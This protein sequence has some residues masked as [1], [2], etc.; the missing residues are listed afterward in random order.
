MRPDTST[1]RARFTFAWSLHRRHC[2]F[3]DSASTQSSCCAASDTAK[4]A[5]R[6]CWHRA[7]SMSAST[8]R[9]PLCNPQLETAHIMPLML[10]ADT[11]DFASVIRPGDT[12]AWGQSNA[13]PL[14]LTRKLL[15]QRHD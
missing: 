5:L 10:E 9:K 3:R 15:E 13:E 14:A 12:V 1:S 2:A 8:K 4:N 6:S 7:S 11:I